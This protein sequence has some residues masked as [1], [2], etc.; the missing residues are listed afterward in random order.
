[1]LLI[2]H[3]DSQRPRLRVVAGRFR[4]LAPFSTEPGQSG[5]RRP[6]MLLD[7]IL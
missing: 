1:M 3:T 6:G 4:H 2:T 5:L 7:G